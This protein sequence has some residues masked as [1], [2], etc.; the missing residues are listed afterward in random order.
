MYD[1]GSQ[2]SRFSLI[3]QAHF[4]QIGNDII[5]LPESAFLNQYLHHKSG[6]RLT[7]RSQLVN[8]VQ[9]IRFLTSHIGNT[10]DKSLTYPLNGHTYG[11]GWDLGLLHALVN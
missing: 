11:K 5:P 1:K 3:I 7:H 4:R 6:K 8:C 2:G 10:V 9:S